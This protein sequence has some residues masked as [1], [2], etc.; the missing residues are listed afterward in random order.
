MAKPLALLPLARYTD[1]VVEPLSRVPRPV[2]HITIVTQLFWRR[3]ASATVLLIYFGSLVFSLLQMIAAIVLTYDYQLLSQPS[4]SHILQ[5]Y[6]VLL[7]LV[8]LWMRALLSL[9]RTSLSIEIVI[10]WTHVLLWWHLLLL[11]LNVRGVWMV[12]WCLVSSILVYHLLSQRESVLNFRESTI[13]LIM[14]VF[15]LTGHVD[16]GHLTDPCS[17]LHS[18]VLALLQ[19]VQLWHISG[20]C[21]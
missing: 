15:I 4:C 18:L 17:A 8:L 5:I 20:N 1:I 7:L 21:S 3:H 16:S 6:L 2:R 14:T 10:R 12:H 19:F 11:W 13:L 9:L